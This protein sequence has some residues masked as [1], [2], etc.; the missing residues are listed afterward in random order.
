VQS[1]LLLPDELKDLAFS[2]LRLF[3][4]RLADLTGEHN[5]AST[6]MRDMLELA[7]F[8]LPENGKVSPA[9]ADQLGQA[10]DRIDAASSAVRRNRHAS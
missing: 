5:R 2:A 10:L 3:G 9:L 1:V 7:E 6:K 8:D 4:Q